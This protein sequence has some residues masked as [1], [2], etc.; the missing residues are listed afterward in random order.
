M[1]ALPGVASKMLPTTLD[2][3]GL[4]NFVNGGEFLNYT[5]KYELLKNLCSM[6]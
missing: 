5:N 1:L 3:N 6:E 4:L 2:G